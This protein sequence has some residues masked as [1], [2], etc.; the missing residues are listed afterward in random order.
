MTTTVRSQGTGGPGGPLQVQVFKS[1]R[2]SIAVSPL[3]SLER[4][5]RRCAFMYAAC[6]FNVAFK[7]GKYERTWLHDDGKY[8]SIW[9]DICRSCGAQVGRAESAPRVSMLS[10]A[11]DLPRRFHKV[12]TSSGTG[13]HPISHR[14][15]QFTSDEMK[16]I[17]R[18]RKQERCWPRTRWIALGMAAVII[19]GYGYTAAMLFSTLDPERFSVG[20][21]ALLFA[22]CWPQVLAMI[23][24]SSAFIALAVR[25]WRGNAY[26]RLLLR[27]LDAQQ[28]EPGGHPN[29]RPSDRRE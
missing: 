14:T 11:E 13:H 9:R 3:C 17:E 28:T 21:S 27:L 19:G 26:R 2:H 20:E 25:D 1:E 22:L 5:V 4:W 15:M 16:L 18:L 12:S 24:L 8:I 23:Y 29:V 7:D 6:R 10:P